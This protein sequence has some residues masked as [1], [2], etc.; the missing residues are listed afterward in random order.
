[1]CTAVSLR[2]HSFMF[3]RTLDVDRP[4]CAEAVISPRRYALEGIAARYAVAGMATVVEGYPLYYDAMNERGLCMAGL[5]LPHSTHYRKSVS[6]RKC[7][8]QWQFIPYI[9]GNCA[10]VDEAE[11]AVAGMAVT[12]EPFAAGMPPAPLHWMISDCRR[13]IVVESTASGLRTFDDPVGVLTNEPPFEAQLFNLNNYMRVSPAQPQNSFACG[14]RLA[15]YCFGMGGLGLPGDWSSQSRFVRAAYV[16]NNY[17][18]AEGESGRN[19]LF[20]VL[21]CVTVPRGAVRGAEGW[22]HTLY[23]CCMDAANRLYTFRTH[24]GAEKSVALDASAA[25]GSALVR[26]AADL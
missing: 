1:M 25:E 21:S 5:N 23:S 8:A 2:T 6:G 4:Y 11:R 22:E 24:L 14:L 19:A 7:L 9:L 17:A 18:P 12:D 16:R 26:V 10:T 15:P 20:K 3:G 13:D